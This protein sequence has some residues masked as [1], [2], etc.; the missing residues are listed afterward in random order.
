MFT[1]LFGKETLGLSSYEKSLRK[2]QQEPLANTTKC[3]V[4]MAAGI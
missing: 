4:P 2:L 3:I 1:F